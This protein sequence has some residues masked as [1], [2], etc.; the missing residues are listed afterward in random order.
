M[1]RI[2]NKLQRLCFLVVLFTASLIW[3]RPRNVVLLIGDGMGFE[4]VR[5]ASMF[6]HGE[7]GK[8]SFEAYYK[9]ELHTH[10]ADSWE[11]NGNC[12]DSAAS[13]TAMATGTKVNNG[14][15][16]E[17]EQGQPLPTLLEIFRDKGKATGLITTV[18]I[19]HATPAGF[20]A[21]TAKRHNYSDIANDYFTQTRPNLLLGAYFGDGKGVTPEKAKEAGYQVVRNL[22]ELN[23]TAAGITTDTVNSD[24]FISGQFSPN[25]MPDEYETSVKVLRDGMNPAETYD[26]LPH[27]SEMTAAALKILS[28]DADGFFLMVEGGRIDGACHGNNIAGCIYETVEFDRAAKITLDFAAQRDDTLVIITADHECG[29]LF[30]IKNLGKGYF[31]EVV[32]GRTNHTGLNVPVYAFGP[33]SE[34]FKGVHDNTFIFNVCTGVGK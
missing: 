14:V 22:Q 5:A 26:V 12:T 27:L 18:P 21:H 9:G 2:Y 8:L 11:G 19:S 15:I 23:E 24:V 3:A 30:V 6:A 20:G 34:A 25:K 33:D 28:Q 7:E 31:P 13:A 29:A 4:Q 17:D 1:S 16:C 32:W 10:S